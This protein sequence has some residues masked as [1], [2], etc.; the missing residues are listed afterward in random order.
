LDVAHA[1]TFT[2]RVPEV[3]PYFHLATV[4]LQPSAHEGFGVPLVEAMAAGTPVVAGASGAMPWL[5][6]GQS[7]APAGLLVPPDDGTALARAVTRLLADPALAAEMIDRGRPRAEEFGLARFEQ[8]VAEVVEGVM[9]AMVQAAAHPSAVPSAA[10]SP[11]AAAADVALRDVTVRSRLPGIGR[12]VEWVRVN[13]TTHF[14]EAYLDRVVE[15]QVNFNRLAARHLF[16]LRAELE[17][18]QQEVAAL[19]AEQEQQGKR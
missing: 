5:L 9:A 15:Q 8:S 11:L 10:G 3:A 14:K 6:A 19:A 7:E 16:A 12:W 17:Q 1:V 2:G 4:Y 18:L 13:S